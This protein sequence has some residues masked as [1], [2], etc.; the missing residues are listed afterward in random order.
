MDTAPAPPKK[1]M[2][3]NLKKINQS[4][5]K[6]YLLY[7]SANLHKFVLKELTS[8]FRYML[9][10][11]TYQNS[12]SD[13]SSRVIIELFLTNTCLPVD[14]SEYIILVYCYCTFFLFFKSVTLSTF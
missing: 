3:K 8:I 14:N 7:V 12:S 2:E 10:S 6:K 9:A 1:K 11:L 4:I 13:M 5:N